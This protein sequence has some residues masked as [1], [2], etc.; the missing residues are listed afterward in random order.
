MTACKLYNLI[1]KDIVRDVLNSGDSELDFTFLGFEDEY[2]LV[3]KYIPL[4]YTIVDLGCYQAAQCYIFKNHKAYYGIDCYDKDDYNYDFHYIAPKRFKVENTTHY[5]ET[6]D[7]FIQNHLSQ[8]DLDTTYFIMNAVPEKQGANK[9]K[10]FDLVKNIFIA[11][12]SDKLKVKGIYADKLEKEY[13]KLKE[14]L[15]KKM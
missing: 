14:E 1:P 13:Y 6:I 11:Y 8:F 12:P 9:N 5:S 10:I 7:E 2:F 15:Y 4:N 3:G